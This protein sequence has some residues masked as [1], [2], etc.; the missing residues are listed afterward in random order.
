MKN[1]K[2]FKL[3]ASVLLIQLLFL[4]TGCAQ[5]KQKEETG[6]ELSKKQTYNKVEYGVRLILKYDKNKEAFIGTAKN[7]SNKIAERTRVEVHLSNGAELGPTIPRNLKPGEYFEVNFSTKGQEFKKWSTHA[8]VGSREHGKNRKRSEQGDGHRGREKGE[9]TKERKEGHREGGE[10]GEYRKKGKEIGEG[11]GGH[12]ETPGHEGKGGDGA[13]SPVISI[14]KSY[15]G[16]ID[17]L[18][19][20]MSYDEKTKS[21]IGTIK[22]VTS[23]KI[24]FVQTEHHLK[25]G[26]R[27]VGEMKTT[28]VG[29][30]KPGETRRTS[31][32]IRERDKN[33]LTKGAFDGFVIHLEM[34][35]CGGSGPKQLEGGK[36]KE[37]HEGK[38]GRRSEH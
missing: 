10:K 38:K 26:N 1:S 12:T 2:S 29:D 21:V 8:E 16:V 7:I 23:K 20:N 22:N 13:S 5:K 30:L 15:K 4:T 25:K 17:G 28:K 27:T 6:T 9:H 32:L 36:N 14:N 31:S 37:K 24:C 33:R 34:F 3:L 19:V 11:K 18:R 35:K